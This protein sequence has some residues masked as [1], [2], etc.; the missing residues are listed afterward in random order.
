MKKLAP[1][2]MIWLA[3]SG[4]TAK[5][6]AVHDGDTITV[7]RQRG[8]GAEKVRLARIDAPE[9]KQKAGTDARDFASG[10]CLDQVVE[11]SVKEKDKYGRLVA[12]ITL[13]DGRNL[14]EW[15]VLE[16]LAWWY[17]A[18]AK[19]DRT[20]ELFEEHAR[21][22]RIGL[23]HEGEPTPPWVWRREQKAKKKSFV[24]FFRFMSAR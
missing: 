18:Y 10:L 20:L 5:V 4:F 6:V 12:N 19:S 24:R 21:R 1:I 15:L 9:L 7:Q 23:W 17:R 8:G 3:C 13:P 2:L 16:G 14:N 22:N 11:V